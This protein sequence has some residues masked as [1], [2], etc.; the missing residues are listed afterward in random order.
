MTDYG[1]EPPHTLQKLESS[2]ASSSTDFGQAN[3]P[4]ESV[5]WIIP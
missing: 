2:E 1:Q 3:I 5:S 4:A